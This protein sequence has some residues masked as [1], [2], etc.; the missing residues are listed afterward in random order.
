MKKKVFIEGMNCTNCRKYIEEALG[1][2]DEVISFDVDV[3][4]KT[5]IIT[6]TNN[7]KDESIIDA[8]DSLG[9]SVISIEG[10]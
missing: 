10:L 3:E 8:I 9:F 7:I 4:N 5:V 2:I 6:A 1:N